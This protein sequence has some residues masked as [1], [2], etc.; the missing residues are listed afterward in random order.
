MDTEYILLTKLR[1]LLGDKLFYLF[2]K[3]VKIVFGNK[4]TIKS[5]GGFYY[6]EIKTLVLY[7]KKI[8]MLLHE[9]GHHV[10]FHPKYGRYFKFKYLWEAFRKYQNKQYSR[11]IL[12]TYQAK[13]SLSEFFSEIFAF[14]FMYPDI[15]AQEDPI[16]YKELTNALKNIISNFYQNNNKIIQA[17]IE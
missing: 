12:T 6:R 16:L 9:L 14:Y 7:S 4:N 11:I 17:I 10:F 15:L 3:D 2:T 8:D 5:L 13:T 1:D